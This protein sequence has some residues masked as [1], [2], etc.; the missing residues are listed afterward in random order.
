LYPEL[1]FF[2]FKISAYSFFT[3]AALAAVITGSYWYARKRGFKMEETIYMLLGMG[4]FSFIGARIFNVCVNFEWYKEDYSRVFSMDFE[5]F[6]LYGG[7]IFA[8]IAG[9]VIG[10]IKKINLLKFADS[11]IPFVG[12]GIA[13]MRIGCFLNGCCFGKETNLPWGVKFPYLSPAHIE[14]ISGNIISSTTVHAV[15]PTQIY[16]LIAALIGTLMAL[17]I[18][19]KGKPAGTALLA[20]GIWFTAFRWLN[21]QFRVLPYSDMM[22]NW[23]YPSIYAGIIVVCAVLL[24]RI[25]YKKK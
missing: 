13:L 10:Q 2:L 12:I 15:H 9:A 14:Q 25:I 20:F 17:I 21:M 24:I 8:V 5:G 23:V 16:E 3:I 18:I 4:L 7:A 19:K 22:I 6:S 1:N 11:V